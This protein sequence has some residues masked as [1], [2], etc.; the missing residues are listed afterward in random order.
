[1]KF[2]SD[3]VELT[4]DPDLHVLKLMSGADS[5]DGAS[6]ND[7]V[8]IDAWSQDE[9]H[10]LIDMVRNYGGGNW[11]A[12]AAALGSGRTGK[13]VCARYYKMRD[14]SSAKQDAHTAAVS[15]TSQR[16]RLRCKR[17]KHP[18]VHDHLPRAGAEK[19]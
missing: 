1:M 3:S 15:I 16:A 10:Q 12:K 2:F 9:E 8:R 4:I 14:N 17:S 19:H 6:S 7:P 18:S 13:A 5:D 11:E